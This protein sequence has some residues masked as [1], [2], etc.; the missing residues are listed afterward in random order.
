MRGR[1]GEDDSLLQKTVWYNS[2]CLPECRIGETQMN[3]QNNVAPISSRQKQG[4]GGQ[5]RLVNP[6]AQCETIHN[7]GNEVDNIEQRRDPVEHAEL[8]VQSS[9]LFR[10]R[11]RVPAHLAVLLLCGFC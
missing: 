6:A 8:L 1:D 9:H 7:S 2:H 4:H 5:E 11:C 3:V 10:V